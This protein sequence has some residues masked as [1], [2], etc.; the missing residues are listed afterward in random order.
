MVA[1]GGGCD[2]FI[3][4]SRADWRHA[5]DIDSILREKGLKSFFDRRNLNPGLPWVRALEQA[6]G[7][8][9]AAVVLIGP[10]GFGNTQQYEREL[11][12]FRQSRDPEFLVVP[13]LLPDTRDPPFTFLQVITWIDFS[14]VAKVSDARVELERL[15]CAVRG[16]TTPGTEVRD[17]ICPYRGLDAFREE[18][19][20]FFFGRGSAD[21]PKSAIGEL[22]GKVREHPF[23]MVVERSGSGKSSLVFAGLVPALRRERDR[24]WIVLSF[25]PGTDPLRA[26]A[27]T[28][29]SRSPDEGA[30]GY[31]KKIDDETEALRTGRPHLLAN[32]VEQYLR[33]AEGR[34][35]RLLLYVDQWEELYAQG[36]T[37]T[38]PEQ[39]KERRRDDTARFLELLLNATQSPFVRVVGTIRADFYDPL[40]RDLG[41]LLP[42]QQ[43]T[44]TGMPR[45]EVRRTITEPARIV[46]LSFDRPALVDQILEDVGEDEGRLPLLQYALKESWAEREGN[47]IT[48]ESY[49]RSGGVRQAIRI[50]AERTFEALSAEDKHAA[51]QLFLRLV[52][53]GEGQ[54]D[55]RVRAA[56][57][58]DQAQRKIVEQFASQRIRLLGDRI[59]PRRTPDGGGCARGADPHLAASP[60][61]DRRK[62]GKTTFAHGDPASQ[63][64]LG[65]AQQT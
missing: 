54:E 17:A 14:Q 53:P 24:F 58:V 33:R 32:M 50:T 11:A 7:A 36:A 57:P 12:I 1:A 48:A 29:N 9:K 55:T 42:A 35:D 49:A 37:T 65:R 15:L 6:I 62:S 46:Q 43:V 60:E 64:R 56:M 31:A 25:Q 3:S 61:M 13:V 38:M 8:A 18:D 30:V 20:A 23:V 51:R 10:H 21:D 2:V 16:G 47:R 44:L 26:I 19:A 27:E 52:T 5:A 41:S 4:Y 28:F 63:G 45:E 40:I 22:V 59:R 34:P 39:S